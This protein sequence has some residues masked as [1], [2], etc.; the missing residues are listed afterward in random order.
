MR[1]QLAQ[2][3]KGLP[4]SNWRVEDFGEPEHIVRNVG[5][6]YNY[7]VAVVFAR[8]RRGRLMLGI[9]YTATPNYASASI[10][11]HVKLQL[12]AIGTRKAAKAM[13]VNEL[14]RFWAKYQGYRC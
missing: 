1:N 4:G 9:Y 12:L 11:C 14:E 13:A 5:N 6:E 2:W 10:G 7:L 3:T 8:P